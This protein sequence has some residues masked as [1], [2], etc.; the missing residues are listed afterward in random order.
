LRTV[1]GQS[2]EDPSAGFL[3][4]NV[5]PPAGASVAER[6]RRATPRAALL[7]TLAGIA[8]GFIALGFLFRTFARPFVGLSALGIVSL[9]YFLRGRAVSRW[10]AGRASN[11]SAALCPRMTAACSTSREPRLS[12]FC[13]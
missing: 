1:V 11:R 3:P 5:S 10:S 2:T 8:L 12:V 4:P 9:T 7:S 6:V 13:P